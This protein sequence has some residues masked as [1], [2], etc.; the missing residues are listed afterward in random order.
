MSYLYDPEFTE[1]SVAVHA[2]ANRLRLTDPVLAFRLSAA[3]SYVALNLTGKSW[4]SFTNMTKWQAWGDRVHEFMRNEDRGF[5]YFLLVHAAPAYGATDSV[6]SWLEQTVRNA[7]LPGLEDLKASALETMATLDG[8]SL[9]A[10]LAAELSRK[11]EKGRE[12]FT[13]IGMAA[14]LSSCISAVGEAGFP[15]ILFTEDSIILADGQEEVYSAGQPVTDWLAKRTDVVW[16]MEEF[17]EVC[18]L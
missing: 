14:E 17:Y 12:L 10:E 8:G 4:Q 16:A 18:G 5:A 7:G 13:R 11:L 1:Y 3:L 6:I 2:L 9:N 15:P